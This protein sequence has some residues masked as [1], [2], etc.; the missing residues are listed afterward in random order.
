MEHSFYRGN[1]HGCA[2]HRTAFHS[3]RE[4]IDSGPQYFC[5]ERYHA[6]GIYHLR[7]VRLFHNRRSVLVHTKSN[8]GKPSAPG[9][10]ICAFCCV[11]WVA[12]LWEPLPHVAPL[13]RITYP[14]ADSLAFLV[15]GLLLGLLRREYA[16][17]VPLPYQPVRAK[18]TAA[19]NLPKPLSLFLSLCPIRYMLE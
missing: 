13:D 7:S 3:G 2:H 10:P 19:G 16:N 15:M 11:T 12:Y 14:I 5:A 18:E 4:S 8:A 6:S 1:H 17:T 9:I